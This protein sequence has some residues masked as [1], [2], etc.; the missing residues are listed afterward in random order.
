LVNTSRVEI[1]LWDYSDGSY[2]RIAHKNLTGALHTDGR[3]ADH[4]TA[5]CLLTDEGADL[6]IAVNGNVILQTTYAR[7][8]SN[9][10]WVPAARVG[11]LAAG[12]GSDVFYDD[13][14]VSAA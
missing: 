13:F 1:G 4:L 8:T 9:F 11:L 3:T 2:H 6:G 5:R 10:E 12:E 7:S 14:S